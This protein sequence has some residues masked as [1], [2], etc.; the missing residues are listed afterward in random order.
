MAFTCFDIVGIF[1]KFAENWKI[2]EKTSL[3]D[4][5]KDRVRKPAPL[6]SRLD[7]ANKHVKVQIHDLDKA[8]NSFSKRDTFLFAKTVKAYSQH[9]LIRAKV[10]ASELSAIRKTVKQVSNTKLALEQISLRLG[11]VSEF[12][13]VVG[14][15]SPS[16]NML[17]DVGKGISGTLPEASQELA[18]I[19]NL[20]NGIMS[21]TNQ[22][23]QINLSFEAPNDAAQ[24]ILNEAAQIAEHNVKQQLPEVPLDTPKVEEKI[25]IKI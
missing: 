12:G 10:Y 21:E 4:K 19:S 6:K 24:D 11:T 1:M 23:S 9:D 7:A 5:I 14:M 13:D 20:L 8:I 25:H 15:L 17:R 16:V 22:S 18:K 2:D 3:S